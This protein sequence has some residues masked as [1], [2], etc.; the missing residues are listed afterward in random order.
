MLSHCVQLLTFIHP[1]NTAAIGV[2]KV[3]RKP[4]FIHTSWLSIFI[5]FSSF[6]NAFSRLCHHV[7]QS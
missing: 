3:P 6:K 7:S 1:H 2:L 4:S 5:L